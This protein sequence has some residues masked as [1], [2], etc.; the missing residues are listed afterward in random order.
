MKSS[1][2]ELRTENGCKEIQRELYFKGWIIYEAK[3]KHGRF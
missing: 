1:I 3:V 2:I